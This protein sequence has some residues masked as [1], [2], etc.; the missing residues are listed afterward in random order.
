MCRYLPFGETGH[1]FLSNL[2]E[3]TTGTTELEGNYF[4]THIQHSLTKYNINITTNWMGCQGS[5]TNLRGY[6][7]GLWELFHFLT[8]QSAADTTTTDPLD[9]LKAVHGFVKHFFGCSDCSQHFQAMA[10]EMNIWQVP[11]KDE[12]VLWLWKAHNQ[13]NRRLAGDIT[14]DPAHKKVQF[15]TPFLCAQC[16]D[17]SADWQL[18]NVLQFLSQFY[19]VANVSRFDDN[20]WKSARAEKRILDNV[21][22][23]MDMRMGIMLY[24]FCIAMMAVAVKLLVRRGYRKKLYSHDYKV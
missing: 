23:E 16:R 11:T 24:V 12:A 17:Q 1:E 10:D 13:V 22:S 15:P 4:K 5:S 9:A 7:C 19:S 14:E 3:M 18:P 6:S 20:D 21:F 8:V 2:A